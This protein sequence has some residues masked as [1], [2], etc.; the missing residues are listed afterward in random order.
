MKTVYSDGHRRHCGRAELFA[1]QLVACFEKPDRAEIVLARARDVGL[2]EILPPKA[3]GREPL[4][5]VHAPEFLEFMENAWEEWRVVHGDTD[6][7]PMNWPVRSFS[8]RIPSAIDGKLGHFSMDAATPITA[9]TWDAATSA[10]DCT[11]TALSMVT[12]GERGAFALVRP[13]GHHA[14]RDLYGGYCFMNNA[15]VAAQFFVDG[16]GERV[17]ILDVDYHH[18]NG[19]QSIFYDRS[20]VLFVS[21][22]GDPKQ[23]FPYFLGYDDER[24]SGT[25]HGFNRNFPL[26]WGTDAERWLDTLD[27]ACDEIGAFQPSLVVVSLGL[28]TFEGDP[29]SHFQLASPDYVRVGA[30]I[31]KLG[32]PTLFVLEGGYAVE[33]LG[34]NAVNVLT[35][36]DG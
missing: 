5:R 13:P 33:A 3:F 19:T 9:G 26:P 24:G 11:L 30:R 20:D 14:S 1:G 29:I 27:E 16:H 25:G 21:V 2:G 17:A 4:H 28:D 32:L 34:V 15:A 6:A 8:E 22:H 18:G 7:L 10:V 31:A 35:G 36:F 23:E 12:A